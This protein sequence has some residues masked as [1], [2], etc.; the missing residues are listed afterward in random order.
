VLPG[1]GFVSLCRIALYRL[2]VTSGYYRRV[3]PIKN[4]DAQPVPVFCSGP[5]VGRRVGGSQSLLTRAEALVNGELMMFSHW[6]YR[7]KDAPDWHLDPINQL[8]CPQ[9][10]HWTQ[11]EVPVGSDIKCYWEMSRFEWAPMLARAWCVS[12]DQ[13]YLDSLNYL[14]NN[15]LEQNPLNQGVN[16]KCGQET[17]IRL[18]N[19]L[20]TWWLLGKGSKD[21]LALIVESHLT[22][23]SKT[24]GYA[25]A[26]NNNHGTSEAAGLFIGGGWLIHHGTSDEQRMLGRHCVE[27]GRRW[28]EDRV[29]TLI[30]DDGGFAQYSTNYH[31]VL[32]DTLS[33]VEFWRL[34]LEQPTFSDTFYKKSSAAIQWL[35]AMMDMGAGHVVN[36]GAND[37]ARLYSLSES[38]YEDFRPSLQ[39]LSVLID[40]VRLFDDSICDEP[41]EWLNL[42]DALPLTEV[43]PASVLHKSSGIV[44][45]RNENFLATVKVANDQFRPSH[46]DC[47]HVD[48]FHRN[49]NILRDSGSFSYHEHGWHSYFS[50]TQ[51][52]NTIQ[53]DEHDQMPRLSKFL[54]AK[55]LANES[56]EAISIDESGETW[57]GAYADS[58][59][60]H[61]RRAVSIFKKEMIIIDSIKGNFGSA[62]LRW[63]LMPGDWK[64]EE[65]IVRM[66]GVSIEVTSVGESTPCELV[67]GWESRRYQQKQ[68]IPVF[69]VRYPG[70]SNEIKTRVIIS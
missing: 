1:L 18:I 16:W 69:Q 13:R 62:K 67:S 33:Q 61:H 47:L 21:V 30:F 6:A 7:F 57:S 46:A 48:L 35:L 24:L 37:G 20:L 11:T 58:W 3:L 43:K 64:L 59:G 27:R 53:F 63:R 38:D 50:G 4:F 31:R 70:G 8:N 10:I 45:M 14:S 26:Q 25:I 68:P 41:L 60:N 28:L 23:I 19:M 42:N 56:I 5:V 22:R 51:S 52:H 65:N 32:L 2:C 39:L 55:W 34:E 9:D 49:N 12:G 66:N 36:L 17:S 44:V 40:G 54:F 29:N 15:W